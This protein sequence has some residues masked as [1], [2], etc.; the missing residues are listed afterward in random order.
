MT[1]WR[2]GAEHL[3]AARQVARGCVALDWRG[4]ETSG[5]L[6]VSYRTFPSALALMSINTT[7]SRIPSRYN[8]YCSDALWNFMRG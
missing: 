4:A 3:H 1:K 8:Q 7:D 5:C 2:V 6:L